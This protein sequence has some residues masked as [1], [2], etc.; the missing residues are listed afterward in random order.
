MSK[1]NAKT[2]IPENSVI[3]TLPME[4]EAVLLLVAAVSPV[5]ISPPL[6]PFRFPI[7]LGKIKNTHTHK[8]QSTKIKIAKKNLKEK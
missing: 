3:V 2:N 4:L 7:D 5:P 8:N 1:Q 6:P